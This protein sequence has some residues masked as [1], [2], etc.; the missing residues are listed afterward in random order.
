MKIDDSLRTNRMRRVT[1]RLIGLV[2]LFVVVI[3]IGVGVVVVVVVE[4]AVR[5]VGWLCC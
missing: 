1:M 3:G 4:V 5:F 2:S